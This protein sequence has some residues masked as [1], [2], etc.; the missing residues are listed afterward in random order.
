[1]VYQW[2]EGA[3][4]PIDAQEAGEALDEIRTRHD[5]YLSA[6]V[7]VKESRSSKAALHRCFEWND[8]KAAEMHREE[9]ARLLIRSIRIVE[10]SEGRR[11][12]EPQRAYINV[13]VPSVGSRYV[14]AATVMSD[15]ELRKQALK[16]CFVMLQGARKRLE[17]IQNIGRVHKAFDKLQLELELEIKRPSRPAKVVKPVAGRR[18]KPAATAVRSS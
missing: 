3:R 7:V 13:D 17:N 1:M 12:R 16:D 11:A 15:R 10:D 18:K 5:G 2:N 4:F 14:P 8:A 9:Q 6:D